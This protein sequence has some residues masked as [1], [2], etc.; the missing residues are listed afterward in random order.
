MH[1]QAIFF[2]FDG[3]ILD[4]VH[5]KTEAFAAMFRKYGPEIERAV[6]GFEFLASY[7]EFSQHGRDAA[8]KSRLSE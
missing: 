1:Y 7:F 2:D 5:V 3:V 4:S 6:F 8:G